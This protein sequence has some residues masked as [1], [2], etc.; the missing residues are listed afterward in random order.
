M[1]RFPT[2][3][4][5]FPV[6]NAGRHLRNA[7]QSV[8]DQSFD[9]FEVIAINDG[10]TDGSERVLR[11]FRDPRIRVLSQENRGLVG[12]LNRGIA[13]SRGTLIARMDQDDR[14]EPDRFA[15]QIAFLAE[16]PHVGLVGTT[17]YIMNEQDAVT[18]INPCLLRDDELKLQLLYQTPFVH[19]S[20]MLRRSILKDLPPPFYR[21]EA[22][23]AEDFDF[24]S[25][26][27]E[28]TN[29]ANLAEPLYGWRNNPTG[30]S[31][32]G[33]IRQRQ[34]ANRAIQ[35][36]RDSEYIRER[37][38]TFVPHPD[39][40]ANE[41]VAVRGQSVHCNRL[42]NYRY[43]LFRIGIIQWRLG[44]RRRSASLLLR[45]FR[46]SPLYYVRAAASMLSR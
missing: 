14:S 5:L 21:F 41:W 3:S 6:Y 30:M 16:H 36:N 12:T 42:E 27:A 4:V 43:F 40:Y 13:E 17:A 9:D 24:W 28:I 23:N 22:G 15:K 33:A 44:L 46:D 37:L 34:F 38:A 1:N 7:L 39:G 32:S 45:A 29:F 26:L 31:N 10:S 35:I 8:L 18:G 2:L 11:E 20:V 25:R 19:G